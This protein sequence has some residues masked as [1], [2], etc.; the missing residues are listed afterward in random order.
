MAKKKSNEEFL[1]ELKAIYPDIQPLDQYI[2]ALTKIRFQCKVCGYQWAAKPNSVLNGHGCPECG[3]RKIGNSLRKTHDQ[4]VQELR[5]ENPNL[6]VIGTYA[7]NKHKIKVRCGKCGYEWSPTPHD[8]LGGHGCPRCGL[9]NQKNAQRRSHQQF[10]EDLHK[11]NPNIQCLDEYHNN[12]QKIH[13]KCAEC[14]RVWFTT[15]YSVL[16]GHGCPECAHSSTSFFEQAILYAFRLCLGEDAVLT[17]NHEMIGM[18]LDIY[19][20]C[21]NVAFEPGSWDWH[22]NKKKRDTEKRK[23]C[24]E[25]GIRLINIFTDYKEDTP[26]Y[27]SDCIVCKYNLGNATWN[28]TKETIAM[29][30]AKYGLALSEQQWVCVRGYAQK[31]SKKKKQEEFISELKE[32]NPNI[33]LRS[34]YIDSASKVSLH[35]NI[36]GHEWKA[37]PN[38]LLSGHGCPVCGRK[39]TNLAHRSDPHT[40]LERMAEI[41]PSI[42]IKE[43]YLG[44]KEKL[45]CRCKVCGNEWRALPNHLLKGQGCPLCGRKCAAQKNTR[46]HAEFVNLL[47]IK[48]SKIEVLGKYTGSA[49]KVL[50]KCKHCGYIWDGDPVTLMSGHGCPKCGGSMKRTQQQFEQELAKKFPDLKVVG[51]YSGASTKVRIECKVCN[52]CWDIR[53]HDLLRGKG[54]PQ[55]RKQK[56]KIVSV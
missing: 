16:A 32:I 2:T 33:V 19:I 44:S 34:E 46:T 6:I 12:H 56:V 36:C 37:T 38:S 25:K 45:L 24:A 14:G 11:V 17:R 50:V 47:S 8:L 3:K 4:F 29:L 35:C 48:N 28:E 10:V 31:K 27:S 7:G 53:P 5:N 26:P 40:F 39:S 30:L 18:E 23:R 13:F 41:N 21:L 43:P 55:C 42:E 49:N 1:I 20:P 52:Y 51:T 15:P 22:Y 9:S 54:C